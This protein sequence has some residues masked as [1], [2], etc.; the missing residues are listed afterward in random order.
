MNSVRLRALVPLLLVLLLVASPLRAATVIRDTEIERYLRRLAEPV[1]AAAG[2]APEGVEIVVLRDPAINA[3]VAGGRR[4]YLYTGLLEATATPEQLAAV[5]AHEAG[6]MAGGHLVRLADEVQR[7]MVQSLVGA[8]LGAA[9]A[10][11]GAPE[12]GTALILGG[13]DV[14]RRRFLGFTRTQEGLADQAAVTALER[15]GIDPLALVEFLEVMRRYEAVAG[16]G[17]DVY[18]RTHP[19]TETRIAELRRRVARSSARGRRLDE[20]AHRRHARMQA[21]IEG[22]LARDPA[23]VAERRCGG[24]AFADAYACVVALFRTGKVEVALNRL[25]ALVV[26]RPDDPYLQELLGQ[27]RFESGRLAAA[28]E[29]WRRAVA[30]VPDAPLLRF[31]LARVLVELGGRARLR[32]ARQHLTEALRLEPENAAIH[33]LLGVVLGR[34]GETAAS[35]VELAEW[36]LRT[37]RL[38]DVALYLERARNA[39]PDAGLALRIADLEQ[40]LERARAEARRRRR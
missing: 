28:E 7:A 4:L 21:K 19:L 5:I 9:A 39:G 16:G 24:A 15:A 26:A 3:F 6:H 34:L 14:A 18:L 11:A 23:A 33:R 8:V 38:R 20:A 22:F 30:L 31:G 1:L 13:Q 40:A 37:G 32:E 25:E 29:P 36:A 12:V 2:L 35:Y 10:V 17:G 27:L